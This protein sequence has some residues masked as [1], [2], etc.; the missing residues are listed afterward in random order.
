MDTT[1][2]AE[3]TVPN[4]CTPAV[5]CEK[6]H[7]S[8]VR[9]F[10]R[11]DLVRQAFILEYA[12]LAWMVME[13]A[14]AIWSGVRA[15]SVSLLAFGID[16]LIELASAGSADWRLAVELRHGQVFAERAERTASRAAGGL[17][18]AL[19]A[20]VTSSAAWKLWMHTGE[21][22][23]WPGLAV[24]ALAM[25]IM[26]VLARRKIVIADTLGSRA[27]RADAVESITCCWLSFVSLSGW[28]LKP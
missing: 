2:P 20:Y 6:E 8:S 22:F 4:C 7:R 23:S 28:R 18:L 19:A 26:Y 3:A 10:E 13:A 17:L 14:V 11:A 12:T 9:S 21:A 16:S 1:P 27:M 15:G 24:A 5:G 25:P